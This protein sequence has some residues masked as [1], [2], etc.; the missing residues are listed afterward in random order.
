MLEKRDERW[1]EE[2]QTNLKKEQMQ[3]KLVL[4]RHVL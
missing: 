1:W 2:L 3:E 4:L